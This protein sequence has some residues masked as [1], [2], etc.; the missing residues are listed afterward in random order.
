MPSRSSRT[1]GK[2]SSIFRTN[3]LNFQDERPQLSGR[4]SSTFRTSVL[5]FRTIVLNFQDERPQ[6][7]DERPQLSGHASSKFGKIYS[8]S[9]RLSSTSLSF[10]SPALIRR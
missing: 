5:N 7:Q 4:S 3:V 1:P 2:L 9:A 10:K 6:F 8:T